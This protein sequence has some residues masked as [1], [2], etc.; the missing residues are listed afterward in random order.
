MKTLDYATTVTQ[1]SLSEW[2]RILAP[3]LGHTLQRAGITQNAPQLPL[4]APSLFHGL[5]WR[6]PYYTQGLR[7]IQTLLQASISCSQTDVL[8]CH[9]AEV[10]QVELGVPF[11]LGRTSYKQYS[12]YVPCLW[13]KSMWEFADAHDI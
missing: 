6:H 9:T 7:H 13:Y 2:D 10:F 4:F 1:F 5:G 12:S 8:L 3:A 11:S